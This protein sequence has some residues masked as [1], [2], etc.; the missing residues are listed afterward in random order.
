MLHYNEV[1]L[2]HSAAKLY[3]HLLAMCTSKKIPCKRAA[4][5]MNL[6]CC[7]HDRLTTSGVLFAI[8]LSTGGPTLLRHLMY[9]ISLTRTLANVYYVS[10]TKLLLC[11]QQINLKEQHTALTDLL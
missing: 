9:G 1:A 3:L 2:M 7:M 8:S 4:L 5:V 6:N 11:K 10:S